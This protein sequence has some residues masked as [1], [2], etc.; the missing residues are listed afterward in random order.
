M[1]EEDRR[2]LVPDEAPDG[3]DA[4]AGRIDLVE[5]RRQQLLAL[6]AAG[7]AGQDVA[8]L[9]DVAAT[10]RSSTPSAWRRRTLTLTLLSLSVTSWTMVSFRLTGLD[11]PA[12]EHPEPVADGHVRCAIPSRLPLSM[13]M[14][15]WGLAL[16]TPIVRAATIE[17]SNAARLSPE[18]GLRPGQVEPVLEEADVLAERRRPRRLSFCVLAPDAAQ[19]E[20]VV[21]ERAERRG[22]RR[23]PAL[24]TGE[25]TKKTARSKSDFSA[26]AGTWTEMSEPYGRRRARRGR[27]RFAASPRRGMAPLAPRGRPL[28]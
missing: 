21:P 17:P 25:K 6:L 10:A 3:P 8:E 4:D 22:P 7:G 13:T 5:A 20:V 15:W 2:F 26:P 18:L 16:S 12:D 23:W 28:R 19:V 14:D 27:G 24:W 9:A 11:G 1:L